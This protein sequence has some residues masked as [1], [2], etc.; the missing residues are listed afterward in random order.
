M[1]CL[2]LFTALEDASIELY[3]LQNRFGAKG[4]L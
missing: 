3:L 4:R 2:F 1:G